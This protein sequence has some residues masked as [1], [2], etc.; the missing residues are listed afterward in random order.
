MRKLTLIIIVGFISLTHL[1]AQQLPFV[2]GDIILNLGAGFG[3]T[4]YSGT[5]YETKLLPLSATLE[6][7][8]A[9]N[10]LDKG[11]LGAGPYIGYTTFKNEYRDGGYN[12]SIILMGLRGNF[13]YPLVDNLDTYAS[14]FL[15]YNR[16]SSEEFGIPAGPA[17]KSGIKSAFY[18]GGRYYFAESFAALVELGYGL[19]YVNIGACVKFW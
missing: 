5:Y 13:H 6:F 19:T 4:W 12:Y 14:L 15:G 18:L 3:S 1:T 16:I 11:A 8:L 7:A 17:E 2:K 9:N 10:V